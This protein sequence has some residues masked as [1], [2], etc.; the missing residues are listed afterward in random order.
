MKKKTLF[1]HINQI[2]KKSDSNYYDNLS[3][4]NRKTYDVYMVHR[5]LSMNEDWIECVNEIQKYSHQLKESGT[6]KV[7]NEIIPKSKTY[8]KYVK[9]T[10]SKKYNQAILDILKKYYE[11]GEAQVKQYYDIFTKSE[12]SKKLLLNI[13]KLYGIQSREY[14][15]LEKDLNAS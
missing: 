4:E 7:Y 12:E 9:S 11:L 2:T 8:L 10:S 3:E 14:T 5:F 13:V 6:H 15:K 1:D